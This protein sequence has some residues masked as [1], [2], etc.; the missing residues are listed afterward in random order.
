MLV[1]EHTKALPQTIQPYRIELQVTPRQG[2]PSQQ[3]VAGD[4]GWDRMAL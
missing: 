2:L 1:G 4:K 3:V